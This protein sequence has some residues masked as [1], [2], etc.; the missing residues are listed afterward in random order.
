M[1]NAARLAARVATSNSIRRVS[2]ISKP[3][4]T[5]GAL[6]NFSSVGT[7][8]LASSASPVPLTP[9]VP[10]ALH[11]LGSVDHLHEE[12]R[13]DKVAEPERR[14]FTYLFVSSIRFAYASSARMLVVKFV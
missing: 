6:S 9:Q 10:A 4:V 2:T 8:A 12:D 13:I 1:M 14:A 3:N 7:R 11:E 5:F